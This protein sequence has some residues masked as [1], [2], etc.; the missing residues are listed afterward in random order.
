[1]S[2][3]A[4]LKL[5]IEVVTHDDF[6]VAPE[7]ASEMLHKLLK[8]QNSLSSNYGYTVIKQATVEGDY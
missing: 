1:M 6:Y 7:L 4:T 3:K 5:E 2:N 8:L